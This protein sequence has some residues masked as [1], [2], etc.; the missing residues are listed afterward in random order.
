MRITILGL[1]KTIRDMLLDDYGMYIKSYS[2]THVTFT[3]EVLLK[4]LPDC[5]EFYF[6]QKGEARIMHCDY[7]RIEIE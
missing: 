5:I 7:W 1:S 4:T 3:S 6:Y 2:D